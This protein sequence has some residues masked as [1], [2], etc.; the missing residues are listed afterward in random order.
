MQYIDGGVGGA[1]RV[2]NG[3]ILEQVAKVRYLGV[4]IE[5]GG[6]MAAEVS[7]RVRGSD[8]SGSLKGSLEK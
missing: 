6:S 8:G 5:A 4:N 2:M 1:G 7:H 3:E